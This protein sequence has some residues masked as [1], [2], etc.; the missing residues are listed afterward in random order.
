M[1]T[2]LAI[3]F[4]PALG[5]AVYALGW[6]ALCASVGVLNLAMAAIAWNLEPDPPHAAAPGPFFSRDLVEWR[7][8][9]PSLA[10]FLCS[11]GYGGVTS[12]VA[13]WT[14]KNGLAPKG[15]FFTVFSL[16]VLVLR[17][18]VGRHA[19]RTGPRR[20]LL[21][22]LGLTAV[23]F[24]LLAVATTRPLLALA[25]FLFGAGFGNVYP[26]FAAHVTR[27][28]APERRG[29]AFGAILAAFDV[30]IGTGSIALGAIIG[31]AGFPVAYGTAAAVA[32]L[33]MPAF[34]LLDR[35]AF[36]PEGAVS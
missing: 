20:V 28:V 32:V 24:A 11:F 9:A 19:D 4:A 16:T 6:K 10:L 8:L 17:P 5:L 12:F 35:R 23:S 31:R 22:L 34:L 15:L 29:A 7:V 18:L 21:P 25:A 30:G 3:A 1:A 27:H 13:M 14:E 33:S 26:V 36:P 2:V